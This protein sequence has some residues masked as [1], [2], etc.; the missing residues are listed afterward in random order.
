MN[1]PGTADW[2]NRGLAEFILHFTVYFAT[3]FIN[4]FNTWQQFPS[5]PTPPH[6][7]SAP[8]TTQFIASVPHSLISWP[9]S[10]APARSP[11]PPG[12]M[13]PT[14]VITGVNGQAGNN[15]STMRSPIVN[16]C[17]NSLF[18]NQVEPVNQMVKCILI[19]AIIKEPQSNTQ[20]AASGSWSA[21]WPALVYSVFNHWSASLF[22]DS[23]SKNFLFHCQL[24]AVRI[25]RLVW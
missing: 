8:P 13:A 11:T 22:S 15:T 10:L 6:S 17:Y 20:R 24:K 19:F 3:V 23:W 14:P 18:Q 1:L 9:T 4:R 12:V 21:V 16:T 25:W 7:F 5:S 2:I